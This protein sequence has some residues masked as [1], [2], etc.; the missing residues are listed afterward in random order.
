MVKGADRKK[1]Q[2]K[3]KILWPPRIKIL[4][5]SH[6]KKVGP[7]IE[8]QTSSYVKHSATRLDIVSY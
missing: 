7:H 3:E 2:K 6:M 1:E 4:K 8:N 5:N